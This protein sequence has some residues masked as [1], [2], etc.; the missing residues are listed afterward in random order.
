VIRD[1]ETS[2]VE[3]FKRI[4]DASGFGYTFPDLSDPLFI[5][6]KTVEENGRAV[7]GL[8]VKVQGEV[9]LWVDPEWGTPEERWERLRELTEEA[10]LASWK[11]GL[12]SLICV[13][14]PEI[15]DNFEKRLK[16]IGMERN[17][18]WPRFTFDLT[19]YIPKTRVSRV[20]NEVEA[21]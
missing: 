21:T 13:V 9:Y 11:K 20:E 3:A 1:L 8:V 6:K 14:P 2:D 7:Q 16:Q 12:D 10:K 19:D 4:H 5:V 18:G 17:L 15:A